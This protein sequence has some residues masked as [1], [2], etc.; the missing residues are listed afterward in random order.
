[1]LTSTVVVVDGEVKSIID[2]DCAVKNGFDEVDKLWLGRLA[3]LLAKA[4]EW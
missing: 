1:M 4:C 2:I 3:E